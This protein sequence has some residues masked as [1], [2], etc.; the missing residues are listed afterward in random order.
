MCL[1]CA[2]VNRRSRA[3]RQG[4][5]RRRRFLLFFRG[6]PRRPRSTNLPVAPVPTHHARVA[7]R[8]VIVPRVAVATAFRYG[9]LVMTQSCVCFSA[10]IDPWARKHILVVRHRSC[11]RVPVT[12]AP[13]LFGPAGFCPPSQAFSTSISKQD[14]VTVF[15]KTPSRVGRCNSSP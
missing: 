13:G 4:R 9:R 2:D 5:R 15:R 8:V 12:L 3:W 14:P 11:G 1:R 10:V 7:A 6:T